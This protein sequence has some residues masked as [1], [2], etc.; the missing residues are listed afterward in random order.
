MLLLP[1]IRPITPEVLMMFPA[2]RFSVAMIHLFRLPPATKAMSA[3][4]H[5]QK[6]KRI[7]R[8]KWVLLTFI[9][10]VKGLCVV[11]ADLTCM[12][13]IALQQPS[14]QRA[15][16]LCL[17]HSAVAGS[18]Y[19]DIFV[20]GHLQFHVSV[21]CLYGRKTDEQL[22]THLYFTV[23]SLTDGVKTTTSKTECDSWQVRWNHDK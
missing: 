20:Y 21:S 6:R 5:R 10:H 12:G 13:H 9:K 18:L 7:R 14:L 23:T 4:L 1:A 3:D 8:A 2:C 19:T 17:I 11:E 22:S 16:P 15:G